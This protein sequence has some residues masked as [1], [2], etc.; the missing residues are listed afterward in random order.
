MA[1][2]L[3][4]GGTLATVTTLH[5]RGGTAEF[6]DH[7]QDCYLRWDPDVTQP[8]RLRLDSVPPDRDEIDDD[9]RFEPARRLRHVQDVRYS[10]QSYLD[11]LRTHSGHR[12][13]DADRREG[14]LGCIADLIERR[15][16]GAIVKRY[17]YELR[18]ARRR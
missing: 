2:A 14:L 17:G 7:A 8:E 9:A 12:A 6:F 15:Y 10:T 5:V 18:L 4:P 1:A 13:L 11:L 16:G 3:R